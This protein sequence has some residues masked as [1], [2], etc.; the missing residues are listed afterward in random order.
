MIE[1]SGDSHCRQHPIPS[2]LGL[3]SLCREWA[4]SG[5]DSIHGD[6]RTGSEVFPKDYSFLATKKAVVAGASRATQMTMAPRGETESQLWK[7]SDRIELR[8]GLVWCLIQW[9]ICRGRNRTRSCATVTGLYKAIDDEDDV[10]IYSLRRNGI[11]QSLILRHFSDW[12]CSKRDQ[13]RFHDSLSYNQDTTDR[14]NHL[15]MI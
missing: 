7:S 10:L 2:S 11:K 3:R 8:L 5:S 1:R 15:M 9:F 14:I 4:A 12:K 6:R 13:G